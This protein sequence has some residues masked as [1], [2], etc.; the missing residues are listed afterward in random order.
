MA[1]LVRRVSFL[2]ATG[3]VSAAMSSAEAP[4]VR[5]ERFLR[6][7]LDGTPY[8][9]FVPGGYRGRESFPLVLFLHG[10]AGRGTDNER[11]LRNGNGMIVEMF[12]GAEKQYPAFVLAPQTSSEH[13]VESTLAV[14]EDVRSRYRIDGRRIYVV[15]QSLGGYGLLDLVAARPRLFAAAVVIAAGGEPGRAQSL[16]AVPTWFFHGEKDEMIPVEGV[17]RLVTDVK[18]AGGTVRFTEYAGEG[19]GLA[20]LVVK[21]RELVPWVFAR[22]RAD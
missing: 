8:R 7:T 20:W 21:E 5:G 18:R 4:P 12:A 9:L 16:S 2:L 1:A 11:H 15:G 3:V 22:R 19:H 10:G 14:L 13:H 17:R 6:L